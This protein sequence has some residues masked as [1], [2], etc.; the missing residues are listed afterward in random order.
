MLEL[1]RFSDYNRLLNY[2]RDFNHKNIK[3]TIVAPKFF[4]Y[5]EPKLS[6]EAV[7]QLSRNKKSQHCSQTKQN[8]RK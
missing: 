8:D 4:S 3:R 1:L 5:S 7:S 2:P 6:I